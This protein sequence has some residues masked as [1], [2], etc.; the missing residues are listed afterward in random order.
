M[1]LSSE[2]LLS[3]AGIAGY[4]AAYDDPA[5]F[6]PLALVALVPLFLVIERERHYRRILA[7][8]FFFGVSVIGGVLIWFW[9]SYPLAW[10]GVR[11]SAASAAIIFAVWLLSA[12]AL[13]SFVALWAA[14]WKKASG[15]YPRGFRAGLLAASLWI[16]FESARAAFFSIVWI[17]AQSSIGPYWTFGFLGYPL[18]WSHAFASLA[19]WGGVYLLSFVGVSVNYLV[20]VAV[21]SF[22]GRKRDWRYPV[23]ALAVLIALIAGN[24]FTTRGAPAAPAASTTVSLVSTAFPSTAFDGEGLFTVQRREET[25]KTLIS[26]AA[27]E[28]P[29]MIIL[30]EDSHALDY[31]SDGAITRLLEAGAPGRAGK[32]VL[33]D[34][35]AALNPAGGGMESTLS[36][37]APGR[38]VAATY[39]KTFL[40]PHGEY[41]PYID[42]F[43]ADLLGQEKWVQDFNF[44]RGY[45]MGGDVRP[46]AVDGYSVG[47]LF[48]S[49]IIPES[50]YRTLAQGGAQFFVNVASGADFHESAILYNQTL[51]LAKMKAAANGRYFVQAGN[52]IPSFAVNANGEVMAESARGVA[53]ILTVSV[54][55]EKTETPYTR[56]GN[57]ILWFALLVAVIGA[58]SYRARKKG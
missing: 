25:F 46:Q 7:I 11:S 47:A 33:L 20:S 44:F 58:V 26:E 21:A 24:L 12:V 27:S 51:S 40:M 8:G 15:L 16:L 22:L 49:E 19:P 13:G 38:G 36:F 29:D 39:E 37:F 48:C 17:G 43:V 52:G 34:S 35:A 2:I 56:Y 10:A 28:S 32:P 55:L 54:P 18:V 23:G 45:R 3:L 57:L 4:V 6:W 53:G 41:L 5:H 1:P 31:F 30:P 9:N 50:L 14:C 42:T